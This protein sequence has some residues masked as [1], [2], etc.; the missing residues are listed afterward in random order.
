VQ[1]SSREY[2]ARSRLISLEASKALWMGVF[3]HPGHNF[4]HSE[5]ISRD[6]WGREAVAKCGIL[7]WCRRG[8]SNPHTLAGT[9]P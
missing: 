2:G 3:R 7:R 4:G 8:D 9:R 6:R 5:P 1:N